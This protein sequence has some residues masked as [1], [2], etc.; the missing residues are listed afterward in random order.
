MTGNRNRPR[1]G[2]RRGVRRRSPLFLIAYAAVAVASAGAA[3]P[4][5]DPGAPLFDLSRLLGV[6]AYDETAVRAAYAGVTGSGSLLEAAAA[7]ASGSA[8]LRSSRFEEA[9]SLFEEAESVL[10][11]EPAPEERS[12]A[13]AAVLS[14]HVYLALIRDGSSWMRY[15]GELE[16][17][18]RRMDAAGAPEEDTLFV[19][20]KRLVLFPPEAGGDPERGI[21]LL[22]ALEAEN[23]G[24]FDYPFLRAGAYVAAGRVDEAREILRLATTGDGSSPGARLV[25]GEMA[26]RLDIEEAKPTIRAI[27]YPEETRTNRSVLAEASGLRT[28]AVLT[29]DAAARAVRQLEAIPAIV[30]AGLDYRYDA[31]AGMVDVDLYVQEA[32]DRTILLF[33]SST[34]EAGPHDLRYIY[35][36]ELSPPLPILA[37][38]D[39][40]LFGRGWELTAV[41]AG[42]YNDVQVQSPAAGALD[43]AAGVRGLAIPEEYLSFYDDHRYLLAERQLRSSYSIIGG[44]AGYTTAAGLRAA[45][46]EEVR[47]D[48]YWRETSMVVPDDIRWSTRADIGMD[49]I[50]R[51]GIGGIVPVGIAFEAGVAH[52]T[53]SGFRA[54]GTAGSSEF[55]NDAPGGVGTLTCDATLQYGTLFAAGPTGGSGR[56][57]V[58][59]SIGFFG[60]TNYYTR[61]RYRLGSAGPTDGTALYIRGYRTGEFEAE[62]VFVGHLD[63]GYEVLPGRV[64]AALFTDAAILRRGNAPD[65]GRWHPLNSAGVVVSALLPW[66]MNLQI[67]YAH[68]FQDLTASTAHGHDRWT[69]T[70]IR[71]FEL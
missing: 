7:Y 70:V 45:L 18:V 66:R 17:A 61:T 46:S 47:R 63:A 22:D 58:G 49:F 1:G 34:V 6:D 65:A 20:A 27:R 55:W 60:G 10:S 4:T 36:D 16:K 23:D 43:V 28:G 3:D 15:N 32:R 37:Y 44:E 71:S 38:T 30:R 57:N 25:A 13:F 54:W 62:T 26:E 48:W 67:G 21:A 24:L 12:P 9:E 14:A 51:T 64:H 31:E 56:A 2:A 11:R 35:V 50:R 40:N 5:P 29:A 52:H 39:E 69:V 33:L 53:F 68:G 8:A 42:V 41:T 59:V 19:Q